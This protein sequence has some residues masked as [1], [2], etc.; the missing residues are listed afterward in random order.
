MGITVRIPS[1]LRQYAE[2]KSEIILEGNTVGE[3]LENLKRRFP[4]INTTVFSTRMVGNLSF[5]VNDQEIRTLKGMDTPVGDKDTL[6][7]I[8]ALAGG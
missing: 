4:A 8:F 6:S 1:L 7:I 2:Q 3:A 5:Y